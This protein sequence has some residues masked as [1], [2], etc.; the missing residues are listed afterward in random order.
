[1]TP[2]QID[3]VFT[4]VALVFWRRIEPARAAS[5][6]RLPDYLDIL[7]STGP[8]LLVRLFHLYRKFQDGF[9]IILAEVEREL[10]ESLLEEERIAAW[11]LMHREAQRLL[12]LVAQEADR[13]APL[14]TELDPEATEEER[15]LRLELQRLAGRDDLA[16]P[17]E[18][19]LEKKYLERVARHMPLLPRPEDD[20]YLEAK[21]TFD[22]LVRMPEH[23]VSA[24]QRAALRAGADT[25]GGLIDRAVSLA[26][27]ELKN[28][29]KEDSRAVAQSQ[30]QVDIE[31]GEELATDD[32]SPEE[33][34]TRAFDTEEKWRILEGRASSLPRRD[35]Q[36]NSLTIIRCLRE[37]PTLTQEQVAER[38]KLSRKTVNQCLKDLK[39][40]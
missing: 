19:K 3:R 26:R 17:A 35:R 18:R 29:Q 30:Q 1:M 38:L 37:N 8:G 6:M 11:Y 27:G 4:Y 16:E 12:P 39:M 9:P 33:W 13:D 23:A 32:A 24:L 20:T 36:R 14:L 40:R 31:I 10:A 22:R 5:G 34:V 25:Y 2:Q 7:L 15:S 28:R 21:A